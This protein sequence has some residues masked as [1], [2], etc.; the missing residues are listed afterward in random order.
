MNLFNK[1]RQK[2]QSKQER[3]NDTQASSRLSDTSDPSVFKNIFTVKYSRLGNTEKMIKDMLEGG[4]HQEG[5][6][7]SKFFSFPKT[8]GS[9]HA[10]NVNRNGAKTADV[11]HNHDDRKKVIQVSPIQRYDEE[12]LSGTFDEGERDEGYRE[13]VNTVMKIGLKSLQKFEKQSGASSKRSRS[14]PQT[15]LLQVHGVYLNAWG[16]MSLYNGIDPQQATIF[17][18][19]VKAD[20]Q[21]LLTNDLN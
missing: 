2:G 15:N 14:T 5:E 17:F 8:A 19:M 1:D 7:P 3:R 9:K 16:A 13:E 10:R 20:R 18:E 4:T 12:I 21:G 6:A 11:S